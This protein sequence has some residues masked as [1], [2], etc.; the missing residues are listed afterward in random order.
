MRILTLSVTEAGRAIGD[1]LPY[2]HLHG[3]AAANARGHWQSVDALIMVIATGAA[4][5]IIAPLLGTKGSD[6]AVVCVDD[7]GE[8]AIALL[9]GH[10]AGANALARE[11]AGYIGARPVITT[12]ADARG[13]PALDALPGY[14]A[15]GDIAGASRM[16]LDGAALEAFSP[17]GW[18]L[19]VALGRL[20]R[21]DAPQLHAAASPGEASGLEACRLDQGVV[22][23]VVTDELGDARE[24]G[25][26]LHPPSLVAGVGTS[27]GAP[28]EE[29][30][31]LL[32]EAL[33][34][35]GLARASVAEIA[36]ID[37]RREEPA[38]VALGLPVRSFGA[39]ELS[40][41]DVPNPSKTVAEAV[42][43]PSVAEAAAL[44]AGG[45]GSTLVSP[46][47]SSCDAT[48]AIARRK[49]P[50]G[51]LSIVGIGPG[52]PAQRTFAAARAIRRAEVVIGYEGYVEQCRDLLEAHQ[53]VLG[54]PLGAE[55]ERC[56]AALE[57]A[58]EGRS[59]A[60]VCSGDPGVYAMASP[61]LE[62]A[63]R[64]AYCAVDI[65]I[66][67][68]VTAALASAALL[69][70]PLAHDHAV[71]SLSDLLT[72]WEVIEARIDAAGRAD[73]PVA[74]YNPRSAKR[75]S[76]LERA[77]ELLLRHRPPATPVG[78][79]T[80]AYRA[81]ARVEMTTLGDLDPAHVGMT[82]CVVVGSSTTQVVNGR[83]VTPR[84]FL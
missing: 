84:G 38:V 7:R 57:I 27:R 35:A 34:A 6:P 21:E 53:Q 49:G 16:L 52:D 31:Y 54:F 1:A 42:G 24:H 29:L 4:V 76:Q 17:I 19:P 72:P 58:A 82:T 50:P 3:D 14:T 2:E 83:M 22:R 37:R 36:T 75:A 70:A 5:R 20:I 60:L 23:V 45:P 9:G 68:G 47:R 77:R 66:F 63:G 67:P 41:V 46:K 78:M 69:G 81:G 28:P 40:Q 30:A 51:K 12:A 71:V 79:V 80:D 73:L 48:V 61:A 11:V 56:E 55:R 32:D 13:I 25:V 59:V 33:S 62:L 10:A 8:S 15:A 74:L 44:L 43:T 26:V 39:A 64:P 65:A 18:P